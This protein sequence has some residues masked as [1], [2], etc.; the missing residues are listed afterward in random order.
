MNDKYPWTFLAVGIFT[1]I[2]ITT[3]VN[4]LRRHRNSN[5]NSIIKSVENMDGLEADVVADNLAQG[6]TQVKAKIPRRIIQIWKT[7]T[8]PYPKKFAKLQDKLRAHNPDYEYIFFKDNEVDN[9]LQTHYPEYYKTFI[10]LPIYI[11]KMDFFRYVTM[12]HFGGFY[13]DLDIESLEPLSAALLQQHN[14]FPV[15]NYFQNKFRDLNRQWVNYKNTQ[16]NL[17]QYAFACETGSEFIKTIV[18]AIHTNVDKFIDDY[19][20]NVVVNISNYENYVY[21]TTGPDLVTL[22]FN[23]FDRKDQVFI[24]ES[25]RQYFGPFARHLFVGMW[26]KNK[27]N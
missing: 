5:S 11:Q 1:T 4:Q 9:F 16:I 2:Y 26:K 15:D 14:I 27:D 21:F 18:D 19:N 17:G 3:F 23:I 8:K 22:M 12:Y 25:N 20:T 10:K 13:F 6:T 24:L 7:F